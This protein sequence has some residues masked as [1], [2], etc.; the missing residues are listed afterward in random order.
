M[1]SFPSNLS[2]G[3][4]MIVPGFTGNKSLI[5]V[6]VGQFKNSFKNAWKAA[7]GGIKSGVNPKGTMP[8]TDGI[9]Y[10]LIGDKA[11]QLSRTAMDTNNSIPYGH[12]FSK[13]GSTINKKPKFENQFKFDASAIQAFN[14]YRHKIDKIKT[15]A[16]GQNENGE[17]LGAETNVAMSLF[18]PMYG[19]N[20]RGLPENIPLFDNQDRIDGYMPE[21]FSDCSIRKLVEL[22]R[23][24]G[25]NELG[26]ARYKFAD[27]MYCKDL[28]MPNNRLI[29]LRKFSTP[30]G[31]NIFR[32][33]EQSGKNWDMT[34]DIGRMLCYF[35]TEDNKLEDIL[36]YD[37]GAT[38]KLLEAEW[39]QEWSKEDDRVSPLG[40]G[41][42]TITSNYNK[43]IANST[44]EGKNSLVGW[45]ST[46]LGLRASSWYNGNPALTN[47]DKNKVYTP[48]DTIQSMYQYEGKLEFRHEF[49]LV[50]RYKMRSYD[51][52]NQK[53]AFLD[54]IGNILNTTYKRGSFWGGR[55]EIIGAQPN[56]AAWNKANAIITD[57]FDKIETM[58]MGLATGSE[59]L[60][61]ILGAIANSFGSGVDKIAAAA[62]DLVNGGGKEF[63]K[64]SA[65]AMKAN[66]TFS[67]VG[68][69]FKNM[70]GRPQLYAFHSLLTGDN[71]GLWHVTIGNPRNPIAAFGNLIMTNCQIQHLGPLGIDDFPTELKVT[72]TLKHARP[73]DKVAIEKMYTKG[74]MAI[75]V[76]YGGNWDDSSVKV[77]EYADLKIDK[78]YWGSSNKDKLKRN[79]EELA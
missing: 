43:S 75:H 47:Y 78:D 66:G 14:K 41:I 49:N 37:F 19:V 50:F 12:T 29:T 64:K 77:N 26:L 27:F 45:V 76:P 52:I 79:C 51:N 36:K 10:N 72:V 58:A 67:A 62:K 44:G 74:H 35:D 16:V 22:S 7:I 32:G 73:R 40:M 5:D 31:D 55:Q 63:I 20:V 13:L 4:S 18:N 2:K 11:G 30:V 68:G 25:E 38:W 6:V 8:N 33:S 70:I 23:A 61:S 34:P 54:L 65:E 57:S 71:T 39:Q 46:N 59:D 15:A 60:G 48:K 3:G 24:G 28:G 69:I 42:N 56:T 21:D 1:K 9:P 53:A 17:I